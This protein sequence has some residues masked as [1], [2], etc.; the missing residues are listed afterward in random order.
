M[1]SK[2][3]SAVYTGTTLACS[4]LAAAGAHEYTKDKNKAIDAAS[5]TFGAFAGASAGKEVA[6][7]VVSG[8]DKIASKL[9]K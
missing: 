4:A 8:M 9:T 6:S 2:I 1:Y 5:M 3:R 7:L